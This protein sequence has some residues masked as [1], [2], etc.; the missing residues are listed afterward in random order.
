MNKRKVKEIIIKAKDKTLNLKGELEKSFK[1]RDAHDRKIFYSLIIIALLILVY[2]FFIRGYFSDQK[3]K[4]LTLEKV[5]TEKVRQERIEKIERAPKSI[6]SFFLAEP[7]RA[8]L[9]IPDYWE[10]NYRIK[11]A[12]GQVSFLYI[13]DPANIAEIVY[14]KLSP[15]ISRFST[16]DILSAI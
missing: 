7:T 14:I 6:I 4:K 16:T 13:E 2:V 5:K 11:E 10:G 3:S 8:K 12:G 9:S 1:I 15:L